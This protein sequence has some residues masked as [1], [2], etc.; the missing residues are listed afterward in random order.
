MFRDLWN[1]LSA[2]EPG[3]AALESVQVIRDNL[4]GPLDQQLTSSASISCHCQFIATA[5]LIRVDNL[6][7]ITPAPSDI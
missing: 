3:E 7:N 4:I 2:T 6:I 5:A 1:S